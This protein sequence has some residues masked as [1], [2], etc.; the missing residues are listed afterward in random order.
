MEHVA[1]IPV[2]QPGD[3]ETV[4]SMLETAAVFSAKGD[5]AEALSWL[6]R[7]AESAG[8]G[9]DDARTL[10][11]ARSVSN[12]SDRLRAPASL[13]GEAAPLGTASV[14]PKPPHPVAAAPSAPS[15]DD[16]AVEATPILLS[17][18]SDKPPVSAR[19]PPPSARAAPPST[20]PSP[21]SVRVATL[22][23]SVTAKT[24]PSTTPTPPST[25]TSTPI[26]PSASKRPAK[27]SS[28]LASAPNA[29]PALASAVNASPAPPKEPWH[30]RDAARVSVVKSSTEPGLYYVRLLEDGKRP[31]EGFEGLLVAL[32]PDSTLRP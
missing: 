10:A 7:A 22:L 11:L 26:S 5:A 9:G 14:T 13:L 21:S 30:G 8:D 19:P 3:S 31:H 23:A 25:A 16:D 17:V 28:P 15:D 12:L 27:P 6:K 29:S 1:D 20:T 4:V 32:D 24:P 18:R 2:P